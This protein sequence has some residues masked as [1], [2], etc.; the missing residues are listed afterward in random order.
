M[1]LRRVFWIILC[2]AALAAGG[3]ALWYWR[4]RLLPIH[5]VTIVPMAA[6]T[7]PAL[8]AGLREE[9]LDLLA[10]NSGFRALPVEQPDVDAILESRM[11]RS[12]DRVQVTAT[13]TRLE[14]HHRYWTKIFERPL[15][16]LANLPVDI[17]RSVA[18]VSLPKSRH[19]PVPRAYEAFLE[20][21]GILR[22]LDPGRLSKAI[23]RLDQ[24]TQADPDFAEAWAWLAIAKQDLVERTPVRPNEVMPTARDAAER[25]VALGPNLPC[26]HAALGIVRLQYDWEWDDARR[27]LDRAL[28]LSP[29]SALIRYWHARW[30]EAMHEVPKA[31]AEMQKA[32]TLDPLSV[33]ILNDLARLYQYQ[34]HADEARALVEKARSLAAPPTQPDYVAVNEQ[35]LAGDTAPASK[36]LNG[37]DDLRLDTYIPAFAFAR[38]ALTLH[39]YDRM[40][41]WLDDARDER[42][43]EIP[44]VYLLPGFPQSDARWQAMLTEIKFPAA[45]PPQK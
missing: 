17:A 30:H 29:G 34:G 6:Q 45:D 3:T 24:A 33:A 8:A 28:K 21:R 10:R 15:R 12:G 27:E 19:K 37:A 26:A 9:V 41:R 11:E 43:P 40:F 13:L 4:F 38:I 35:A 36:L 7:Q 14:D 42:S 1:T 18:H 25:S 2:T 32:R 39:E 22:E 20:G 31:V 16:D 44:Y 5:S 23:E